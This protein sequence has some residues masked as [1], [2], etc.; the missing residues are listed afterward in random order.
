MAVEIDPC[1]AVDADDVLRRVCEGHYG[2]GNGYFFPEAYR[3]QFG[4]D[5][6]DDDSRIMYCMTCPISDQCHLAT[7][8]DV[9]QEEPEETETFMQAVKL[10]EMYGDK[11]SAQEVKRGMLRVGKPDPY[12]RRIA[13]NQGDGWNQRCQNEGWDPESWD[14]NS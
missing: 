10:Q 1:T 4:I 7:S 14:P 2:F 11:L 6:E 5:P 9:E 12:H 8:Q 3:S 13:K